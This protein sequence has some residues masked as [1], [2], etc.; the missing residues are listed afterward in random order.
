VRR[1]RCEQDR[2]QVLC[3]IT[4]AGLEL[5]ARL[6]APVRAQEQILSARLSEAEAETLVETLE[7]IREAYEKQ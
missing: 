3:F 4:S 5:L 1:V 7:R 6:D 2:R